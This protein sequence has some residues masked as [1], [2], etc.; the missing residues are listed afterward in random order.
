MPTQKP[1]G[2]RRWCHPGHLPELETRPRLAFV[3]KRLLTPL[4][5]EPF[6]VSVHNHAAVIRGRGVE[7]EMDFC[8]VE[9]RRIE[10]ERNK[11]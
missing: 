9:R 4:V 7:D 2:C 5:E 10:I 8:A 3:Y 11:L 1:E 6:P